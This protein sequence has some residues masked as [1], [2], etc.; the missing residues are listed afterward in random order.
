MRRSANNISR[1]RCNVKVQDVVGPSAP[2][3]AC[4]ND[5][6]HIAGVIGHL[7]YNQQ[8]TRG[9][10]LMSDANSQLLRVVLPLL[11]SRVFRTQI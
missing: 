6:Y 11:Q 2:G 9:D 8:D 7:C 3:H 1:S 10:N 5:L 4:H